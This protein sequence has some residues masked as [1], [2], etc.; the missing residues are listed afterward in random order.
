M[1]YTV[2]KKILQSEGKIK[3]CDICGRIVDK[4][5]PCISCDKM[6]CKKCYDSYTGL[7]INCLEEEEE[8]EMLD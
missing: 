8:D 6:V 1:S 5:Y 4:L 3:E 2:Y 7:C